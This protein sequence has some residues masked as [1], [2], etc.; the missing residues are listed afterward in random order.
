L[1]NNKI[2]LLGEILGI[3]YVQAT[4]IGAFISGD[5]SDAIAAL[6]SS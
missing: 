5:I 4:D 3:H 1:K 2:T 6:T